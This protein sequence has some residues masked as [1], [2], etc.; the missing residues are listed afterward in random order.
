MSDFMTT[1]KTLATAPGISIDSYDG[2]IFVSDDSGFATV[3]RPV[4]YR[5]AAVFRDG[6]D[7]EVLGFSYPEIVK[8]LRWPQDRILHLFFAG[9]LGPI[10][11]KAKLGQFF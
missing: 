10:V 4:A 2:S 11:Q 5:R 1:G 8:N 9:C 3:K 7:V 6:L